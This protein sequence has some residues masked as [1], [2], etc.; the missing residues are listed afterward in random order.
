[1]GDCM[2]S[3]SYTTLGAADVVHGITGRN[4]VYLHICTVICVYVRIYV[5]IYACMCVCV[6]VYVFA[7]SCFCLSISDDDDYVFVQPIHIFCRNPI[8][9]EK[10]LLCGT[11]GCRLTGN[12]SVAH[13]M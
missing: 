8:A 3:G 12:N 11:P 7:C 9:I 13:T 2:L 4:Y 6:Y 10:S 5:C 1:M